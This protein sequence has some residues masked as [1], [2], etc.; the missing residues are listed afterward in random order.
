MRIISIT[1]KNFRK[2]DS[3]SL[4]FEKPWTI[5]VAP[6]AHGKS[7]II[8]ALYMLSTGDS[9]WERQNSNIIRLSRDGAPKKPHDKLAQKTGRIEGEI[10]TDDEIATVA[11]TLNSNGNSTTKQFHVEG[12]ST[13][14]Q[15]FIQHV[16]AVLFSPDMIDLLMFEP[17]QRRAF[18]DNHAS[19]VFPDYYD[20][21]TNYGKVLRQR[22]SLLRMIS[23]KRYSGKSAPDPRTLTYWTEQLIE[24]GSEIISKRVE[25]ITTFNE[26]QDPYPTTITYQPSLPL[27]DMSELADSSYVG[28]LFTERIADYSSKERIVGRTLVGPHRDDWYLTSEDRN[29]NTYGSRGE[30]RLAIAD[31][32]FKF[33]LLLQ[34]Q[35]GRKPILLLDDIFSELDRKN[36][37]LVLKEKLKEDQQ[38]IITTTSLDSVPKE[39]Q[40]SSH[41]ISL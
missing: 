36:T 33:N 27:H 32:I 23:G 19:R 18:L 39:F 12:S 8:E 4:T 2:F 5:I 40:E 6:N 37:N 20:V 26:S 16:H 31:I 21:H 11:L 30:K 10:E 25:L 29:L 24:L 22:N 41:I 38:T 3:K 34:E 15:K 9:P 28:E 13:N 1:M 17:A 7:S 14:R 35:I